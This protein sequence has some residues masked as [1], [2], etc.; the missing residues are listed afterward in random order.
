MR[1]LVLLPYDR[2]QRLLTT[3]SDLPVVS[4]PPT[5]ETKNDIE[6]LTTLFPNPLRAKARAL[7]TY[8]RPYVTWN[9]KGEVTISGE[10]IPNSNIIDLVKAVLQDYKNFRPSGVE[11][12]NGVTEQNKCFSES[13]VDW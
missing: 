11:Q 3:A 8:I 2:Y 1:K 13:P 7:L 6:N 5:A 4:K 12:F 9:E 10:E